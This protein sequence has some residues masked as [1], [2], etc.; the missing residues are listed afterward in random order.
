MKHFLGRKQTSSN[1]DWIH[2]L[3]NIEELISRSE[4]EDL[5]SEAVADIRAAAAE[6]NV[7]YAWSGGKDSIVLSKLCEAAGVNAGYYAYSDLDYPA[8]V[9]WCLE[10]KPA[11]VIPMHTGYNLD[12]LVK[13][14]R[15]IF[16]QG[17]LGQRWHIINQRGPFTRMYFDN[18]LDALIVGHRV[19]DG[20]VCGKDGYI[21]KKSGEV[22]YAPIFK[23]P[24]EAVLGFIHY[25][26]LELPPIY[27]WKDG[28]V[29]GTHAWP[30]REFCKTVEQGYREVYEIDPSIVMQ[31]AERLPSARSFIENE[32]MGA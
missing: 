4:V 11:G 19:I 9:H 17:Q 30:E 14:R 28:F 7:A 2:A 24:H 22:R 8:F 29:I 6:K 21:R 18:H 20:N 25:N 23:W 27:G 15:L 16:A 26:D 3:T 10:N 31:A 12:W 32:V 13:H 5:T 1:A